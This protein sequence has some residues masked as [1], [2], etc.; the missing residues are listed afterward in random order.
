MSAPTPSPDVII[1]REPPGPAT[2]EAWHAIGGRSPVIVADVRQEAEALPALVAS[3]GRASYL[4]L[5]LLVG[6]DLGLAGF[7]LQPDLC[8]GPVADRLL[9]EAEALRARAERAGLVVE[10]SNADVVPLHYLQVA[11]FS[12]SEVREVEGEGGHGYLGIRRTHRLIL[13]RP[14]QS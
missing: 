14:A 3:Q 1:R 4:L 10:I 12:L 9:A 11:G 5:L 8:Q 7:E 2:A 6:D 13:R